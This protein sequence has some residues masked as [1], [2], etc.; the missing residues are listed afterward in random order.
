[1]SARGYGILNSSMVRKKGFTL[2]EVLV[3]IA[4]SGVIITA[5][6]G[7][8]F[9]FIEYQ[10]SSQDQRDAFESVR[11][12][13]TDLSREMSFGSNY[14]C[15]TANY[16]VTDSGGNTVA[17]S[18]KCI[19]FTDQLFRTTKVRYNG[20]AKSVE[21]SVSLLDRNPSLCAAVGDATDMNT[22]APII[23]YSV[24][25]TDLVFEVE[26][27]RNR[28]PRVRMSIDADYTVDG[29]TESISAK[30][31]VTRRIIEPGSST[32]DDFRI[33]IDVAA[34]ARQNYFIYAPCPAGNAACTAGTSVCQDEK[35]TV[36]GTTTVCDVEHRPVAAEFTEKGLY[37][38]TEN[39]L[40]F[41]ISLDKIRGS[42]GAVRATGRITNAAGVETVARK[43]ITAASIQSGI[44]R[45][46]G[47][48]VGGSRKC[49]LCDNDPNGIVS[50]HPRKR[51][52]SAR[53]NTGALYQINPNLGYGTV[54]RAT[55]IL[56]G[57][58]TGSVRHIST[59]GGHPSSSTIHARNR[60]SLFLF[61]DGTG[62]PKLRFSSRHELSANDVGDN[63]CAAEFQYVTPATGST[64]ETCRQVLPDP[65][66]SSTVVEPS[67]LTTVFGAA[68]IPLSYIDRLQVVN[69]TIHI[70][71]SDKTGK[72]LL[73]IG[74]RAVHTKRDGGT[75]PNALDTML[76][77]ATGDFTLHGTS[78]YTF[79]CRN[80]LSLCRING[81]NDTTF[82]PATD[83]A[84]MAPADGRIVRHA[85]YGPNSFGISNQGRLLHFSGFGTTP[86]VKAIEVFNAQPVTDGTGTVTN[87]RR[88]LCGA[89]PY[90][91]NDPTATSNDYNQQVFFEY[92]SKSDG[93]N[94]F[95][96][97]GSVFDE[98]ENEAVHEIYLLTPTAGASYAQYSLSEITAVCAASHVERYH[99]PIAT[100]TRY[101]LIRLK[102]V[103]FIDR[104]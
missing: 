49:R 14:A 64:N 11:F 92:I 65:V 19:T 54:A 90:K 15:S 78:D 18:C 47:H 27:N 16:P 59:D 33:G 91:Y 37:V 55:R 48:K 66:S 24:D 40:V 29:V 96:L 67:V 101:D 9:S 28:Q 53:S 3:A 83:R 73:S 63:A 50:L 104:P 35:G 52:L 42:N 97:I 12:F 58:S 72:H 99:L 98:T 39:G 51:S 76:A 43:L 8:F 89:Q 80:G 36:Y 45:V 34:A 31:Q 22:W 7:A 71:Y 6:L 85:G 95:A 41:F 44:Q 25:V 94:T 100:G 23:D 82:V 84:D 30:T 77:T 69:E 87:T 62:T 1:M 21:K 61:S 56:P 32:L 74:N 17:N 13:L 4:L 2:V 38:L 93:A 81:I 79:I 88:I 60:R 10:A 5:L 102:G 75:N 103:R 86:A 20:T 26:G 70:W 68:G 46:V 57:G